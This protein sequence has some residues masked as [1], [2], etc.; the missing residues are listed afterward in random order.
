MSKNNK[1]KALPAKKESAKK[2]WTK[3]K[4]I[5]AAIL[6]VAVVSFII[7]AVIMLVTYLSGVRPI[8]SSE[9]EAR[10]VG[11]VDGYEVRYEELRYITLLH[12][13]S[14]DTKHGK[15]DTL[16]ANGKK[17]YEAELEE[18]VLHDLE[19]N[20]IILSLCEDY[21]I[22][23]DSR[24]AKDYAQSAV[25]NR[26]AELG[27]SKD[28]YKAWLKE[29]NMTDAFFRL[30]AKNVY[31]EEALLD[32]FIENKID[33]AYDEESKDKLVAHIL[34]KEG[35]EW[36]RTIHIYYPKK[37]D[38]FDVSRSEACAYDAYQQLIAVEDAAERHYLMQKSLIAK[39]PPVDGFSTMDN[40][41]Y[42]TRGT[43][44]ELYENAAFALDVY[45]ASPVVETDD[46]Y[47]VI[48]RVP[49]EKEHLNRLA[50]DLLDQYRRAALRGK[51]DEKRE[52]ISFVG[53]DY[54]KGLKLIEIK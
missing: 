52:K 15:Y 50:D 43:M 32:H 35:E 25:E 13:R 8:K 28:A 5:A 42:F 22:D 4:K 19:N 12:R 51:I 48:M 47:Y 30:V 40:G 45:E 6:G 1:S 10:V 11:E 54:F 36:I 9:E 18:L 26:Y 3:K 37:H 23:T 21:G 16:D 38:F 39:A 14:L 20:Y 53:N 7:F 33:I 41:F 17:A 44:G 27:D 24:E 31:L 49:M 29:N 46:G 2:N 34:D